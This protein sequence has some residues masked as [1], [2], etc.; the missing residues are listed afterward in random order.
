NQLLGVEH[1][2]VLLDHAAHGG[3]FGDIRQRLQLILQE[4]V[5]QRPQL[6]QVMAARAIDQGVLKDPT[7]ARRIW[8]QGGLRRWRQTARDLV[9]IL[10]YARACP[11]RIGAIREQHVDDR[12]TEV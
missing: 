9:E 2:L 8:P 11:V 3:Y 4:P 10:Q 6:A 1:D 12:I 7:Y 5:L